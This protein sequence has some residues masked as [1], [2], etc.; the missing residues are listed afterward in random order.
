ML[1]PF[2]KMHGIGND[3]VV[4]D[5]LNRASESQPIAN[6]AITGEMAKKICDRRLGVGAD[7][8]LWLKKAKAHEADVRM[9]ILNA[10]GS[11]AEMCGNGI[12]AAALYM[13]RYSAK[14]KLEYRIETLAGILTVKQ[15]GNDFAVE[16]GVPK[17]ASDFEKI[18]I[19]GQWLQFLDVNVGNPHA[20]F[21]ADGVARI[22]L[23]KVGPEIETHKRFPARTN[24]EF[25]EV[26]HQH[27]IKIRVWERGAGITLACGT[28]ACASAVASIAAGK[29]RSPLDVN[30]PGGRLK[31][32]WDG[33]GKTIVMEGPAAEVY[34]G[35]MEI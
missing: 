9:E 22:P 21:F 31:I 35:E 27:S 29:A 17:I 8:I 23:E 26:E 3:F 16:M 28:G 4:I 19:S 5:S 11:S 10:D 20:V 30:L 14:K 6:L 25:V 34:R 7:Q 18:E 12:R 15:R 33:P 13:S 32:H 1:L 2:T 24:V